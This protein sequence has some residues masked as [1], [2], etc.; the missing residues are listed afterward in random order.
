MSLW[1]DMMQAEYPIKNCKLR[2]MEGDIT[3]LNVD[4]IV[5]A[6]NSQLILGG[7]VAG[8]IREKG[9]PSI[10]EEC[11]KIGGT[12]VGGAVITGAGNLKAKRVIHAVGPRMGEG[13]ENKKLENA[14][15]N[16]LQLVVDNRLNTVAFPAI[17]T[18]IFGFP[19][20]GCATIMTRT[21]F[22]FLNTHN[23]PV[24]VIFCL[25]GKENYNVFD[26]TVREFISQNNS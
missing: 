24:L 8:A 4:V 11:R 3:E 22:H 5:N 1:E 15:R 9:G 12:F 14:I 23:A 21:T 6:A 26:K 19:T 17:S 13:N 7:G 16:S 10:Q 25:W 18:G 20:E 2:L